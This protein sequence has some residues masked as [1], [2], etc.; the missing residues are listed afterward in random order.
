[1]T[2]ILSADRV[3]PVDGE[4]IENGA[5]AI[6]DGRIVAVGTR[7]ELGEGER[8]EDA[9]IVPGF[10]NA[11]S[12]L[13]YAVYA[14]FAD[15]QPF[16]PWLS[17]HIER[18]ARIEWEDMLAIARLGAAECL[19]SGVT[20]VADASFAGAAA[21]AA[22]DLGL[23]ALVG[24]EVFGADPDEAG[25]RLDDL[26]DRVGPALSDRVRPA[27]SPHAPYS[28]SPAVYE[29][30]YALGLPAITHVAE[31]D[32]E[33]AYLRDGSGP[34]ALVSEVE[35]P[36]TTPV[37]HL[38]RNGLLGP[39][40]LAAHCVKVDREEIELLAAHDVAVAHCPRSNAI[41]GC[42]VAPLAELRAAGVRVGL[43]TD[44]PASTPSFDLFEEAR[45]AVYAAR[46]RAERPDA[47]SGK[48]ALRLATLDAASALGLEDEIGSLAPGKRA[49]LAVVSLAGSPYL[50]WED[51]A[52]AVV[53]GGSPERVQLTLVDGEERY[54]KGG[55]SWH[56]LRHAAAEARS[57]L[58]GARPPA[59]KT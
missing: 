42:G 15:G 31:S 50:P 21:H 13:E 30:T 34:I 56:E 16:G 54:R 10:V 51:P 20:T 6:A 23:R 17:L 18:K 5:V 19:R 41:L 49:D 58:L 37:R 24:L 45:A 25:A 46:A 39:H 26:L 55:T 35:P 57:R 7:D 4:P 29:R 59:R 53:F 27:V 33:L 44:S 2:R 48:D 14:G 9:A 22:A 47:L 32:D 28:V 43:G 38:A 3:V 52:A 40:V 8:F 36:G 12:H 11:H 1:V